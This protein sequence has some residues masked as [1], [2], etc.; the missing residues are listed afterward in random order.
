[1][2]KQLREK[3]V[4]PFPESLVHQRKGAFGRTLSYLEASA[5]VERLNDCFDSEWGFTIIGHQILDTQ[6]VL[7]HG[8]LTAGGIVKEDFGRGAIVVSRETGE[9]ISAADAF[10]AAVS[11]CIKRCARL[12][13]IGAYLYGEEV[14]APADPEPRK[15]AVPVEGHLINRGEEQRLTQKQ[16]SAIWALAR[17]VGYDSATVRNVVQNAFNCQLEYLSRRDASTFI[18]ELSNFADK[19]GVA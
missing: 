9:V 10:K 16:L 11:D 19:R 13:G 15:P 14:E 5:V 2:E 6:E 8:R 7:V 4:R 17:K 18:G 12:L 1:M 3:L